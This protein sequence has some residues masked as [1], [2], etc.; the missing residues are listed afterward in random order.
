MLSFFKL[1]KILVDLLFMISKLS[2]NITDPTVT[3]LATK[4]KISYGIHN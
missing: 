4:E 1:N 3:K 2:K